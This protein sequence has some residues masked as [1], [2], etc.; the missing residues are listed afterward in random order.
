MVNHLKN[1][2][3]CRCIPGPKKTMV[4]L[5]A[6]R[7]EP[8]TPLNW[9]FWTKLTFFINFFL[10]FKQTCHF[11]S[12]FLQEQLPY[13]WPKKSA[14][15]TAC[16]LIWNVLLMRSLS[17]EQNHTGVVYSMWWAVRVQKQGELFY[18][19]LPWMAATFFSCVLRVFHLHTEKTCKHRKQLPLCVCVCVFIFCFVLFFR[20]P[21]TAHSCFSQATWAQTPATGSGAVFLWKHVFLTWMHEDR[22]CWDYR[23]LFACRSARIPAPSSWTVPHPVRTCN[24]KWVFRLLVHLFLLACVQK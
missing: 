8:P 4:L 20:W 22:L 10:H 1:T 18:L 7:K 12:T 16:H 15:G 21:P 23:K 24:T 6:T 11:Q 13:S 9:K 2:V 19:Y 14:K 5:P 17:T 3:P